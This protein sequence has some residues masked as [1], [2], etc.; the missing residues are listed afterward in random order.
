ML[1]SPP[2]ERAS[3]REERCH[4]GSVDEQASSSQ[5]LPPRTYARSSLVENVTSVQQDQCSYKADA[6][7]VIL[8][9]ACYHLRCAYGAGASS[10]VFQPW[11]H[12][13]MRC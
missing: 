2:I 1:L 9:P 10:L 7:V 11:L 4:L 5:L 12:V 8:L 13:A 3:Q 6:L